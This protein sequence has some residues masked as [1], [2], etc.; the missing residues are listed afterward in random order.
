MTHRTIHGTGK[1]LRTFLYVKDVAKAFD[2]IL[3]K[4]KPF[5]LYN[6]AGKSEVSVYEVA[7][8][9]WKLMKKEGDVDDHIV[10]VRDREFNDF[11][12][13]IDGR[14][15]EEMGWK[16]TTSFEDGMKETGSLWRLRLCVVEWYLSH[17][18]QWENYEAALDAHPTL[19]NQY[20]NPMVL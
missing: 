3:H 10:Y 2:L 9:I 20:V 1:N 12:Y 7:K 18:H 4:G 13:A 14:K 6:I 16:A 19:A 5:E 8:E 11:R 17:P 15:L